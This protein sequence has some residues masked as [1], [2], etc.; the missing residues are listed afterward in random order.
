MFPLDS[1][2]FVFGSVNNKLIIITCGVIIVRDSLLCNDSFIDDDLWHSLDSVRFRQPSSGLQLLGQDHHE[3][4][5]E[6]L[7]QPLPLE[8][9][10][11]ELEEAPLRVQQEP[12]L[13]APHR[14][15]RREARVEGLGCRP[16]RPLE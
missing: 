2:V 16:H 13:Q 15:V 5:V 7:G 11:E 9:P 8:G 14:L 12:P 4:V 1:L 3:A 6:P 10:V